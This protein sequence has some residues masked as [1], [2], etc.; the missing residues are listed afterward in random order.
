M[1]HLLT[2]EAII[3]FY[4]LYFIISVEFIL[5]YWFTGM[6]KK[7]YCSIYIYIIIDVH[8]Y[9]QILPFIK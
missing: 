8:L 4:Y 9:R 2:R 7:Y 3:L 5:T 6:M 1:E